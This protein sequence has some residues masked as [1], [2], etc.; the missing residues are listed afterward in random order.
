MITL[1]QC[2]RKIVVTFTSN[3]SINAVRN[4]T[5]T[6]IEP[7]IDTAINNEFGTDITNLVIQHISVV[8]EVPD[9]GPNTFQIYPKTLVSGTF[10]GTEE[11]F[12][13][14]VDFLINDAK[15]VLGDEVGAFGGTII[16]NGYHVHRFIGGDGDEN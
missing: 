4:M 6:K 16:F 2:H 1:D 10:N 11:Q 14:R 7:K 5:R 13:T 15:T 12:E 9:V 3:K 8:K